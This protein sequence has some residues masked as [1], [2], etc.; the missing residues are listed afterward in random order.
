M[1]KERQNNVHDN[2]TKR[3][4]CLDVMHISCICVIFM[5]VI[6][7]SCTIRIILTK[8][9]SLVRI[10][11]LDKVANEEFP[12]HAHNMSYAGYDLDVETCK[13]ECFSIYE[14]V[15]SPELA[16]TRGHTDGKLLLTFRIQIINDVRF[17]FPIML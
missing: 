9:F 1:E 5:L 14:S 10:V 15:S 8:S 11:F 16:A 17:R 12:I 2:I 7:S 3:I 6:D 4:V 13:W